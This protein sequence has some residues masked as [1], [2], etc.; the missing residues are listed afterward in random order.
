MIVSSSNLPGRFK[1]SQRPFSRPNPRRSAEGSP[2]PRDAKSENFSCNTRN[3]V[4]SLPA[5]L[6]G[7]KL[8]VLVLTAPADLQ[9]QP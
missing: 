9:G 3:T 1:P 4:V 2:S 5:F 7:A 8:K 6:P